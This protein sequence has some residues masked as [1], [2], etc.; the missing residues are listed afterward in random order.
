M[1]SKLISY[2][3][4]ELYLPEP[5]IISEWDTILIDFITFIYSKSIRL[6]LFFLLFFYP[7]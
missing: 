2:L 1:I 3:D 7:L 4:V 5:M 6:H